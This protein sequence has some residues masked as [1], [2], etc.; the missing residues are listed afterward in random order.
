MWEGL[1]SAG[2]RGRQTGAS[3]GAPGGQGRSWPETWRAWGPGGATSGRRQFSELGAE[4]GREEM[5]DL[6]LDSSERGPW[7]G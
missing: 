1:L 4:G 6:K 7:G 5:A 2:L 3:W